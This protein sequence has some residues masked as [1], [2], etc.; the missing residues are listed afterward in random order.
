MA[1]TTF[2]RLKSISTN[3]PIIAWFFTLNFTVTTGKEIKLFELKPIIEIVP[4]CCIL[5]KHVQYLRARSNS[6]Q[7]SMALDFSVL[8][9]ILLKQFRCL[10][11]YKSDTFYSLQQEINLAEDPDQN[12]ACRKIHLV[13]APFA[14]IPAIRVDGYIRGKFPLHIHIKFNYGVLH[15]RY[16]LLCH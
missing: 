6:I 11:L 5:F 12:D 4:I 15:Q 7:A 14:L 1:P 10:R 8:K 16:D 2:H 13:F 9:S 3:K